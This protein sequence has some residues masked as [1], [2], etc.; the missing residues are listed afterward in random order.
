MTRPLA[1]PP[2]P[3]SRV[4]GGP[5][6]VIYGTFRVRLSEL[7]PMAPAELRPLDDEQIDKL[8]LSFDQL[9]CQRDQPENRLYGVV[10]LHHQLPPSSQKGRRDE[11]TP[12][13]EDAAFWNRE[14]GIITYYEGRHRLAAAARFWATA[15]DQQWWMVDVYTRGK[16]SPFPATGTG[17]CA[18][19]V[20]V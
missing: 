2:P 8:V 15:K 3:T 18:T 13:D 1:R 16:S 10:A 4:D 12:V 9:G 11:I 6:P 5:P 19:L 17:G 7:R 14:W 20:V